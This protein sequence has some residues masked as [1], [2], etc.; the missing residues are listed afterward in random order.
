MIV[1]DLVGILLTVLLVVSCYKRKG[2]VAEWLFEDT[3]F[4]G[5]FLKII[6][7]LILIAMAFIRIDWN[8]FLLPLF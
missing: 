8:V 7:A 2:T 6:T 5:Y 4:G 3:G 1:L